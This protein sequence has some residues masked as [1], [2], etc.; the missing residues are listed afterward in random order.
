[1]TMPDAAP[2]C[3]VCTGQL[4]TS[5]ACPICDDD[6]D[7]LLAL[8]P[9]P[10]C[11]QCDH[12]LCPI[13]PSPW[14]DRMTDEHP[15]CSGD[16]CIVFWDDWL[17]WL[18]DRSRVEEH[19]IELPQLV[20]ADGPWL[21]ARV[22]RERGIW[23]SWHPP[24]RYAA[25]PV[26]VDLMARVHT[27][28]RDNGCVADGLIGEYTWRQRDRMLVGFAVALDRE[29][30]LNGLGET[31]QAIF[32]QSRRGQALPEPALEPSS[33]GVKV[34]AVQP[35]DR[36]QWRAYLDFAQ[37]QPFPTT[38]EEWNEREA[39]ARRRWPSVAEL[40]EGWGVDAFHNQTRR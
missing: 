16:A 1:M 19:G 5:G 8:P 25:F 30:V 34:R 10:R 3:R 22:R 23:C 38:R 31:W 17:E 26:I 36:E 39:E 32:L 2:T 7:S 40:F 11:L 18:S 27:W 33:R 29:L 13:C 37:A 14:C 9:G 15:C 35:Q 20:I 28:Q 24:P 12:E 4:T 21:P 6:A